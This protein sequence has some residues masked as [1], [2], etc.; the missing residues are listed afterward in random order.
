MATSGVPLE[1]A[2]LH[3]VLGRYMK[4]RVLGLILQLLLSS[5]CNVLGQ[6]SGSAELGSDVARKCHAWPVKLHIQCALIRA[7]NPVLSALEVSKPDYCL[8]MAFGPSGDVQI[9]MHEA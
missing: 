4:L 9:Y 8:Y 6:I 1:P 7:Q 2:P 5:D 3:R